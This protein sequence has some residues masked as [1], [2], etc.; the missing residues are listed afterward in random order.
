MKTPRPMTRR[1][2][3]SALTLAFWPLL[4]SCEGDSA[5]ETPVRESSSATV[6]SP[7]AP[8]ESTSVGRDTT[9]PLGVHSPEDLVEAARTIVAF[10]RGDADF[11]RIRV[12]DTVSLYL[13]PEAGGTRR[14]VEGATLRN[15]SNWNVRS[16]SLPNAPGVAYS[17]VP[18]K[19]AAELTIRVG[20]HLKCLEYPLASL[21][22]DLAEFPHAGTMLAYDTG[23]LHTE[24]LTL[25]FDPN[26]KPPTLIAAV[27]D[28]WE[29]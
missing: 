15:R 6:D 4:A 29:W 17:F 24:N 3:A 19:G 5:K 25:V 23:C 21:H 26:R 2:V 18:M 14:D 1:A 16:P 27:Y 8:R 13:A 10:L 22:K 11:D 7:K 12:A 28:Q 9:P 20:R